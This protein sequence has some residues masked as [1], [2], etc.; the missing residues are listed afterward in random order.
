M[1]KFRLMGL[2]FNKIKCFLLKV[3][4]KPYILIPMKILLKMLFLWIIYEG[5]RL[6]NL[7]LPFS[8]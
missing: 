2:E 6:Q 3:H 5:I 8:L 4:E 7:C 1:Y